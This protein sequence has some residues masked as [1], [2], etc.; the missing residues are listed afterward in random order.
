MTKDSTY[1]DDLTNVFN[2]RHLY[3][4]VKVEINAYIE[5]D[6]TFSIAWIDIDHF[7]P[8]NDTH[9]HLKGDEVIK[10]F[11]NFVKKS[12]RLSDTIVRYGGDEFVCILPKMK[13][14]DAEITFNRI[15]KTCREVKP[16]GVPITISVGIS[17]YPDDSDDFE[18]LL[19]IADDIL[20]DAKR[21][22]RDRLGSLRKKRIEIPIKSFIN[23]NGEKE[24]LKQ[25][26]FDRKSGVKIAL[27][28]GAVG[29]GKTRLAKE[30]L[31]DFKGK[32][33]VWSDCI[34][35]ADNIAYYPIR[36]IIKYRL[37]RQGV[38]ILES[39][40]SVYKVEISKLIP[41]ILSEV[42][43]DTDPKE[44]VVDKYRLYESV[45]LLVDS[46]EKEKVIIIDNIQWIDDDSIEV[47]KYLFRALKERPIKC[48]LLHRTE[49]ATKGL[50]EL[51][52]FITRE[53][54]ARE[55]ALLCFPHTEIKQC[56]KAII[57]EEPLDNLVEYI[58]NE[59][60]GNP[61]YIEQLMREL[62]DQNYLELIDDKWHFKPPTKELVPKSIADIAMMKYQRLSEE[63]KKLLEI[64]SVL[65]KFD[66]ELIQQ[67]TGFNLG[68]IVGLIG[69]IENL[70]L[71][72]EVGSNLE[73]QDAISRNAIYEHCVTG[74]KRRMLHKK[75]AQVLEKRYSEQEVLEEL[76]FHYYRGKE[77][78]KG[79]EFCE[80]V[81]DHAKEIYSNHNAIKYYAWAEELLQ[82]ENDPKK[83]KKAMQCSMKRVRVLA[84][85]GNPNK[86]MEIARDILKRLQHIK[87]PQLE[88][89][90]FFILAGL[91][92]EVANYEQSI[93]DGE[94]SLRLF[95]SFKDE[96][97]VAKVLLTV[98]GCRRRL[99]NYAQALKDFE[100]AL[101]IGEKYNDKLVALRA[102]GNIG[103]LYINM[104]EYGSAFT[105][106]ELAGKI[107]EEI[108]DQQCMAQILGNIGNICFKQGIY[109]E[110]K[111]YYLKSLEITRKIGNRNS[112]ANTMNNLGSAYNSLGLL[113]QALKTFKDALNIN[114]TIG[115]KQ[116]ESILLN[117]MGIIHSNMGDFASAKKYY[118]DSMQVAEQIKSA[119]RIFSNL[120]CL[121][122]MYIELGETA[123]A[124][125]M[126]DRSYDIGKTSRDMLL[127]SYGLAC[128][129]YL[130]VKDFKAFTKTLALLEDIQ[131]ETQSESLN[132]EIH[133]LYGRCYTENG[134]YD[135]AGEFLQKALEIYRKIKHKLRTGIVRF[136]LGEMEIK[137]RKKDFAEKDLSMAKEIFTTIGAKHW[138][139]KTDKAL[140]CIS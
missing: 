83:M 1:I 76:A 16:A 67:I 3:E 54:D 23:R 36:E 49:E 11:A 109:E 101:K 5:K 129:Y 66:P 15:I 24:K 132:A 72:K 114:Q 110:A 29:I 140:Q 81:G 96:R 120:T 19:S 22:G 102:H 118:E 52:A 21:S 45:K 40:P 137:A 37:Q 121:G 63:G 8:I 91:G 133:I 116:N 55:V 42:K 111:S 78:D 113:D 65:G 7:K 108:N 105:Q 12:L 33:I 35:L 99:S 47:L 135:K 84:L 57:G 74:L 104:G 127:D 77:I 69:D 25:L 115:N 138:A 43:T 98:G 46:G 50:L 39:I 134:E 88:A 27:I 18:E 112:E 136:Y 80:K 94:K 131:K 93:T 117:N 38:E 86:G 126:L 124:K 32:E 128:K 9:G 100:R 30:L 60:G 107:A 59:S 106:Y 44:F 13:K 4:N 97:G 28:K 95:E 53:L 122:E 103:N 61:F 90:V 82:Q 10:E 123:K 48:I 73:F 119:E 87:D 139:Q 20:Y 79:A 6:I 2:R 17:T 68:H 71:V 56:I 85:I 14:Q 34:A 125:V 70:G 130:L 41:E 58:T 75:V 92:Y 64:A 62:V 89:E 31:S 26:L 51:A